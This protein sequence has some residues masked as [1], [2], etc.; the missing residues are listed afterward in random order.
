MDHNH[1]N[2]STVES[3]HSHGTKSGGCQCS[4]W[5]LGLGAG[6]SDLCGRRRPMYRR[7]EVECEMVKIQEKCEK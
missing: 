1:Y 4:N 2:C 6:I 5:N 3:L 7:H